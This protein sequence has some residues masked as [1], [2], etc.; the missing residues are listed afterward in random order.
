MPSR[1][2][3]LA[4]LVICVSCGCTTFFPHAGVLTISSTPSN[5]EVYLDGSYRGTTPSTID[6]VEE[7]THTI[8][9][10]LDGYVPWVKNITMTPQRDLLIDASLVQNV[11]PIFP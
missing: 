4:V 2:W 7:G 1:L 9:L 10:R 5:A 11:S 3:I 6:Y 8:E